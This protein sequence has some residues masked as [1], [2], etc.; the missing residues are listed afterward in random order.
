MIEHIS[1]ALSIAVTALVKSAPRWWP[2][3]Q[4]TF[5]SK[6]REKVVEIALEEG[7]KD[8]R[9]LIEL[10][11]KEQIRHLQL[12]LKNAA[13]RG[14]AQFQTDEER[15]LYRSIIEMLT[16][17]GPHNEAIRREAM[18]LFTL[19]SSP[20]FTSLSE[21]YNLPQR[22]SALA[23]HSSHVEVDAVPY[24]NSFFTAL[25][26]ELYADPFFRQSISDV[27]KVRANLNMQR[28][29]EEVVVTLRQIYGVLEQGYT[30]EQFEKDVQI[31]IAH[32]ERT[33][34][35][36]KLAGIVPKERTNEN[37]N[38]ELDD[39]FVP[40][41]IALKESA[42]SSNQVHDSI[43]DLFGHYS[44]LILLGGPGLGKS[45][46]TRYLAWSHALA[47]L[48]NST[49][50]NT[51]P[52]LSGKPLPLRIELRRLVE[53]RKQCPTYD[54]LT[55]ASEIV[56][57]RAGLNIP[58]QMFKLLLERRM[59]LILFDGLDEVAT[60][61]D[62]RILV[63][64]IDGFAQFYPG[65]R[66][67]VTSR[68]VGYDL[69]PLSAKLFTHVQVKSFDDR[70]I[71]LFLKKWYAHVLGLSPLS[72][73]DQQEMEELY[74]TLKDN[75][76]LHLL[77][78]NPLLLTVITDLHRYERLPDKR[79]L[80]YD[81][82]AYILLETWTKLRGMTARW[83][84]LTLSKEDQYA[85]VAHLGFVLHERLQ[86]RRED[87]KANTKLS[88][89]TP[90][91]DL[92]I[93]VPSRFI[94][95]EIER[96][97]QGQNLFPSVAEQRAHAR[98]F[99]ELIQEEAGLIVERGTDENGESL[100]GF[101]HRTFQ[102]Y[103][104]AIDVYNRYRQDDDPIIISGFLTRHLHDPHWYEV[105]LLLFGKLGRKPAT[106]QLRQILEGTI[107]SRRSR[108]T[109]LIQQDLFFIT[110]CLAEEI[111]VEND[112][113]VSA[114][115][116]L[117]N[118]IKNSPFL[119][120]RSEALKILSILMH[121]RQY[122]T[123]VQQELRMLVSQDQKE[124]VQTKTD[125]AI[126]LF[127]HSIISSE[128]RR[129]ASQVLLALAKHPNLPIEQF[130]QAVRNFYL[131]RSS[132][133]EAHQLAVQ[134]LFDL[135]QRPDLS[136]EQS[137][138]TVQNLYLFSLLDSEKQQFA[139][140]ILLSLAKHPDIPIEQFI[141]F[142]RDCYR[143]SQAE[144][145]KRWFALQ[146]LLTLAQRPDLSTEQSIQV[147]RNLYQSSLTGSEEQ[148][149]ALQLLL[150]LAQCPD[151]TFKQSVQVAQNLYLFGTPNSEE[152]Q[153]A[154]QILLILAK[155]SDLPVEQ[156]IQAAENLYLSSSSGPEEERFASQLLLTLAQRP[157]LSVEQSIRVAQNLYQSSTNEPDV[158]QSAIQ[159]LLSLAQRSDLLIERFIQ[160][161]G[162]LSLS[163]VQEE[164][165]LASQL[166]LTLAQRPNLSVEQSIQV[167]QN[168]YQSSTNEPDVR[169]SAIQLLLSLAQRSDLLV[170][171]FIQAAGNL[172]LFSF[173]GP[174]EERFASQL[175]LT[176]AQ[177]P[178]LSVEQS[179]QVAQ[180]L[181]RSSPTGSEEK[182]FATQLL[183]NLI[184]HL[185]LFSF[186]QFFQTTQ[187]LY[188]FSPEGSKEQQLASQ[189]LLS[190]AQRSDLP[191][192]QSIQV[193]QSLYLFS[194]AESESHQYASQ[195]LL[196]LARR[197]DLPIE[198]FIQTATDLYRS[199][200]SGP[201]EEYFA[202]QL[203]LTLVQ[204]EDLSISQFI[205]V[206]R[207]LYQFS[208]VRSKER[209][210]ASQIL[211]NLA[212]SDKLSVERFI[213]VVR[214][215]QESNSFNLAEQKFVIQLF[216]ALTQR[217]DLSI[218]QS[219]QIA[220]NLY[221]YSTTNSESR[222][223]A[224]RLLL[225]IAQNHRLDVIWR[226]QAIAEIL[227]ITDNYDIEKILAA[228]I[229]L[230]L[231]QG[232]AA[233]QFFEEHWNSTDGIGEPEISSTLLI[234]KLA[235]EE[236]LPTR[237]QDEMYQMLYRIVPQL[238]RLPE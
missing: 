22:I 186:E 166:L 211:L 184:Q 179:I 220:Q 51:S 148:R 227:R 99:L 196:T 28:S 85:C 37:T 90:S 177:R 25:I 27:L 71:Y 32:I 132:D 133:L 49:S 13:E 178:N 114:I 83:N 75:P 158:R 230:S 234:I 150:V 78:E 137:I 216:S 112:L 207:N 87:D 120:Q 94:L 102:E 82:C 145:N 110:Y 153:F 199:S 52:L 151:L 1:T 93:D 60:L 157:N 54:F 63:D 107:K 89:T 3:I 172:Y 19:S 210:Y 138:K 14:L 149:F 180:N 101:V 36:L 181:Y 201:T 17:E 15:D 5:L 104:A 29:L 163:D 38:P 213:Q 226:L 80:V 109:D 11:E 125:V 183:L 31:Y 84:N 233:Q 43:T 39:I 61:N 155:R 42:I 117:S 118:L 56:L 136:I 72:P 108:F 73:D 165:R 197:E 10:D 140:Q 4:D 171:Q 40:L 65:N 209:H 200:Y 139:S 46:V 30:P 134:L 130:F 129:F 217:L 126:V 116:Q 225:Q 131:S 123:I 105:I 9:S 33:L 238:D 103:F 81:R 206:A 194:F 161:A 92:A 121:T 76:H 170:E 34:H 152:R 169:Q 79:I 50:F 100:Y 236:N 122:A 219:I 16:E 127:Q 119:A 204:R 68:P 64:E 124:N 214:G 173:S 97:L 111:S 232:E 203:L 154:S 67:L 221:F 189:L 74:T 66:F 185:D 141:Q 53:E 142:A 162:N 144:S 228:E 62:R 143:F 128:E 212:Q 135:A 156:F 8:L 106:K 208:P 18:R 146:L 57:S 35:Y 167:A 168:L 229:A 12:A 86:E 224:I 24:L 95:R 47:N 188:Q 21:T 202:C 175:L 176:L 215:I 193:A 7:K 115:K 222:L 231:L 237:M 223:F 113:A 77:A 190:L 2:P 147:A 205:R 218:K 88:D 160:A 182:K 192:E 235:R 23:L 195:L 69:A 45:T 55:Y 91:D 191:V 41:R 26:S 159:L 6:A 96:F 174:E 20:N 44:C 164:Q 98:H 59:M 198:Q 187:N 70:Q 48:S 58:P